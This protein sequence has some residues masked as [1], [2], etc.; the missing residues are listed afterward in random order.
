MSGRPILIA[1]MTPTPK[2]ITGNK[3]DQTTGKRL[4]QYS[5]SYGK[6]VIFESHSSDISFQ[7]SRLKI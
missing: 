1:V 5:L 3:K 6:N 2:E 7:L 4:N